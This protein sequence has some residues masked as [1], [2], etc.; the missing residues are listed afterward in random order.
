M[1]YNSV[2]RSYF[3]KNPSPVS[4]KTPKGAKNMRKNIGAKSALYPMPVLIIGTYDTA[5]K[6]FPIK[7]NFPFDMYV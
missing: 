1:C 4:N 7:P 5:G 2:K 3:T 6:A